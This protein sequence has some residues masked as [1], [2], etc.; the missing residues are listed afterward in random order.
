MHGLEK[1][2]VLL[3]S[4][5]IHSLESGLAPL[6]NEIMHRKQTLRGL[7]TRAARPIEQVLLCR[8]MRSWNKGIEQLLLTDLNIA[9]STP[10]LYT[11]KNT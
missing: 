5:L 4:I 11:M 7:T 10:F 2:V 8:L 6:S 1:E 3:R 9:D